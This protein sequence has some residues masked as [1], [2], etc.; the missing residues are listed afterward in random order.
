VATDEKVRD[1]ALVYIDGATRRLAY[2]PTLTGMLHPQLSSV[3]EL[4]DGELVIVSAFLTPESW[5]AFTTRRIISEYDGRRRSLDPTLGFTADFGN[6]KG[7][8]DTRQLGAIPRQ[9]ATL[10]AETSGDVVRFEYATGEASMLPIYAT[11]Y[12]HV[13]HPVIEKLNDHP[14]SPEWPWRKRG[15]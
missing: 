13:K 4:E 14:K 1:H 9:V 6:F 8:D 15:T 12:W 3:L 11:R 2:G 10:T 7:L 5:Y